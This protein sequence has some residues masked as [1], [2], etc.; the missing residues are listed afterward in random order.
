MCRSNCCSGGLLVQNEACLNGV[1]VPTK[2]TM[3]ESSM[4]HAV[5]SP[6]SLNMCQHVS[7]VSTM[8]FVWSPKESESTACQH[9]T[10]RK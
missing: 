8:V 5:A 1:V 10:R 3:A 7:T 9:D 2:F 4:N 6:F